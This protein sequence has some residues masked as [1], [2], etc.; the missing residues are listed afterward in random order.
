MQSS[1]SSFLAPFSLSTTPN[2]YGSLPKT[3]D[4]G[5]LPQETLSLPPLMVPALLRSSL[6]LTSL[7][8]WTVIINN[9]VHNPLL[10]PL[11]T[12]W[13][14]PYSAVDEGSLALV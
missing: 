11:V 5:A 10:T 6:L 3:L 12:S 1:A 4:P 13:Q 14:T 7:R 2:V 9:L 8:L